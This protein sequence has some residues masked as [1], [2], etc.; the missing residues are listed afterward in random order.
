MD[1][2]SIGAIN[3]HFSD[4][5]VRACA[6]A[7]HTAV[8]AYDIVVNPGWAVAARGLVVQGQAC[9]HQLCEPVSRFGRH[10]LRLVPFTVPSKNVVFPLRGDFHY[11]GCSKPC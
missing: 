3:A 11:M 2:C 7:L 1:W 10:H 5:P 9:P 8:T 4:F 6:F